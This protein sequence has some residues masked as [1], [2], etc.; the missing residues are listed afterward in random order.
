MIF[1]LFGCTLSIETDMVTWVVNTKILLSVFLMI[2][3]ADLSVTVGFTAKVRG[4]WS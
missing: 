1:E 3:V 4:R 2:F